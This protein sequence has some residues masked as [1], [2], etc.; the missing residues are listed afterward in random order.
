MITNF[1]LKK[2]ITPT[3]YSSNIEFQKETK[4]PSM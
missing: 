4:E 1:L 2:K 3:P